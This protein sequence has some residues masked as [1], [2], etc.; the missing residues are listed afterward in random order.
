[1]KITLEEFQQDCF[2][3]TAD[4]RKA[5]AAISG[6]FSSDVPV[7]I[8][9]GYAGT[10]KTTLTRLLAD[11]C[12]ANALKPVLMAPTG[13][14]AR[15]AREKTGYP[16]TTIHKAIYDMNSLDEVE[17]EQGSKVQYKYRYKIRNHDESVTHVF[18]VDEASMVSDM[19][20]EDDFFIFGSGI[21]LKDL[22][23]FM[24]P[25]NP[26]RKHKLIFI[27][28]NAQL[29][30]VGDKMSGALDAA[31]LLEKYGVRALSYRLTE[32]VRQAGESVVLANATMLREK[33][34]SGN[35]SPFAILK[36]TGE[37]EETE[38]QQLC[39]LWS[40]I[41]PGFST[42][43]GIVLTSKNAKALSHNLAIR[44]RFFGTEEGIRPGETLMISQN[45][46]NYELELLNG[47]LVKVVEA[48]PSTVLK[49]NL[50]SYDADGNECRVSHRFRRITI[51]APDEND[52]PVRI[53]CMILDSFLFS[54][55]R[56]L[57]YAEN[58]ALYI[59]FKI[60]HPHL[61]PKTDA[62]TSAFRGDPYVNALRV[63]FG[64][65][66][67]VHKA[68]GG[69]WENALV[70]MDYYG[71][72]VS[73]EFLR[74]AY[75]AFTRASK[76]L[77]YFNY[78]NT[79][80][81]KLSY[82]HEM[83]LPH[84]ENPPQAEVP[85][86]LLVLSGE[87]K[88]FIDTFLAGESGF[89]VEKYKLMLVQLQGSGIEVVSRKRMQYAE[90]YV[91]ARN[92][93]KATLQLFYNGKNRFTKIGSKPAK[94]DS[95]A[96]A[97]TLTGLLD[98]VADFVVSGEDSGI[99]TEGTIGGEELKIVFPEHL[100]PLAKLHEDLTELLEGTSIVIA[101]VV[102]SDFVEKYFFKRGK[103]RA[104]IY[105]WYNGQMLFT[106]AGPHLPEC[107]SAALLED[108]AKAMKLLG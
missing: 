49:S 34:G 12:N 11:Y 95:A 15:I 45:N 28:D 70:D 71:S 37:V 29:P 68:Q 26:A 27:G 8:L 31:H 33:I 32:V 1:M 93:E 39:R 60:R 51:E 74:W 72:Y 64:Y 84:A 104:A 3:P 54:P 63:K 92:G 101:D 10:G 99:H 78:R 59:D 18:F 44:N 73:A 90:E 52:I 14:A 85:R 53:D 82:R 108:V 75:T 22:L 77:W 4:Q 100:K 46:Y 16:A 17:I 91:F 88:L 7:F 62:F 13:R 48:E 5:I 87:N 47:T 89:L 24:A 21:V 103:E 102:H 94:G 9:S 43:K 67:T 25:E 42:R 30:P 106:K 56:S 55:E 35:H 83:A 41:N 19:Y 6:F 66:V 50:P 40:E 105:F 20:A 96:L 23:R 79:L 58:I 86:K 57:D 107:D 61:K 98:T 76:S 2:E 69:E 80:Y 81:G 36:K 97:A 65:A 38:E